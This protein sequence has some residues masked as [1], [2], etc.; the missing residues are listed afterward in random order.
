MQESNPGPL[1]HESFA[2]TAR[3]RL[4]KFQFPV[5]LNSAEKSVDLFQHK[6]F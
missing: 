2:L 1:N 5:F 6:S 4:S 3:S